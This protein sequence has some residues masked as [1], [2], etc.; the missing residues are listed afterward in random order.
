MDKSPVEIRQQQVSNPRILIALLRNPR[1]EIWGTD[2]IETSVG[3]SARIVPNW[4][5]RISLKP[6]LH[7]TVQ[8]GFHKSI[9]NFFPPEGKSTL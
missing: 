8:L 6:L 5:R 7:L 9:G 2:Q 4:T 1:A 3:L